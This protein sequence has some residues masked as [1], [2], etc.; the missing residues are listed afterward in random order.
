MQNM[1][2][3]MFD[4]V[5]TFVGQPSCSLGT[6][7]R[8]TFS[9][10][11]STP[12]LWC[13]TGE[14]ELCHVHPAG[15][16]RCCLLPT[17]MFPQNVNTTNYMSFCASLWQYKLLVFVWG[18][19]PGFALSGFSVSSTILMFLMLVLATLPPH[20]TQFSQ[21]RNCCFLSKQWEQLKT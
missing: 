9:F 5:P 10:S 7:L 14:N 4:W 1:C 11:G 13:S 15:L 12:G 8:L 6:S 2:S 20:Y 17:A 3:G 19:I 21:H 18:S 16:P